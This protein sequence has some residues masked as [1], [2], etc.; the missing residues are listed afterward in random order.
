M[1][2]ILEQQQ[3]RL[4]LSIDFDSNLHCAGVDLLGLIEFV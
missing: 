4:G 2:L 1:R 3:P